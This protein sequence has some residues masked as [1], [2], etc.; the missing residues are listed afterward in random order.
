MT[1]GQTDPETDGG[2]AP[3]ALPPLPLLGIPASQMRV[4]AEAERSALD[5]WVMASL[6]TVSGGGLIATAQDSSLSGWQVASMAVFALGIV[7]ALVAGIFASQRATAMAGMLGAADQMRVH[8]DHL[9][10][11][12]QRDGAVNPELE[13]RVKSAMER[14]ANA[15]SAKGMRRDPAPP[16]WGS[17][18]CFAAGCILGGIALIT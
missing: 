16:M 9:W 4:E 17:L 13:G 14:V 12:S 7:C 3:E 10:E 15:L 8:V 1:S 11:A 18:G 5:R 2:G 6:I